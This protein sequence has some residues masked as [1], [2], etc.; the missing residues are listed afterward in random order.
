M[1]VLT[2]SATVRCR[3]SAVRGAA[4]E[5]LSGGRE[6]IRSSFLPLAVWT[7]YLNLYAKMSFFSSL[8]WTATHQTLRLDAQQ[9]SEL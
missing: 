4:E 9:R 2:S 1:T 5:Y 8:N 3:A 7:G 6:K